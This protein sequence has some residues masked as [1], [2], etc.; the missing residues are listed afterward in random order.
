MKLKD[1]IKTIL[2]TIFLT[3]L[4]LLCYA[5][6]NDFSSATEVYEVFIDGKEIGYLLDDNKLYELINNKQLEIKEKYKVSKVYPPE[7][8]KIIK[9]SSYDIVISTPEEIYTK[10]EQLGSFTIEGYTINIKGKD[11][12]DAELDKL[13]SVNGEEVK[14]IDDN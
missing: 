5:K 9:T 14:S 3:A 1:V 4:C 7:N 6:H 13:N 12:F 8:F 11:E 2:I 10:M